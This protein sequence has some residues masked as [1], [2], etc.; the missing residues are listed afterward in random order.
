MKNL[1]QRIKRGIEIGQFKNMRIMKKLFFLIFLAVSTTA[2]ARDESVFVKTESGMTQKILLPIS[3]GNGKVV[4]RLLT[5][6]D[7]Q[8]GAAGSSVSDVESDCNAK[9]MRV[10]GTISYSGKDGAGTILGRMAGYSDWRNWNQIEHPEIAC[11]L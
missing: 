2:L 9:K 3:R 4:Y 10:N 6:F 11:K 8:Y 7:V 1:V 5:V